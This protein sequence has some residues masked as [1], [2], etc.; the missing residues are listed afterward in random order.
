MDLQQ[1]MQLMEL[2][3]KHRKTQSD[4][5]G[6]GNMPTR[7]PFPDAPQDQM[8][9]NQILGQLPREER[10]QFEQI[11]MDRQLQQHR[12]RNDY[13]PYHQNSMDRR[14]FPGD[15]R[16]D[17]DEPNRTRTQGPAQGDV[18]G[19]A[20][21]QLYGRTQMITQRPLPGNSRRM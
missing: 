12:M 11:L 8:D 18:L 14:M 13:F 3:K 2:L 15:W 21:E 10:M 19:D 7:K 20:L 16:G 5:P 1:L 17:M 6:M 4:T 9:L